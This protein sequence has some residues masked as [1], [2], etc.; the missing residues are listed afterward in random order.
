MKTSTYHY[1]VFDSL[2]DLCARGESGCLEIRKGPF[3]GT[4]YLQGGNVI[5][6]D[7]QGRKEEEALLEMLSWADGMVCW[8]PG[9]TPYRHTCHIPAFELEALWF[10]A[11]SQPK[12]ERRPAPTERVSPRTRELGVSLPK[13]GR[14]DIVFQAQDPAHRPSQ[15]VLSQ[16]LKPAYLIGA[17]PECDI[18]IDHYSVCQMHAALMIEDSIIRLWDLGSNNATHVNGD[19]VDE[20][21]LQSGDTLQ[22]G[23]ITF[24]V[25]LRT[26]KPAP[27]RPAATLGQ[28]GLRQPSVTRAPTGP[29]RFEEIR[30]EKRRSESLNG[31]PLFKLFDT[32]RSGKTPRP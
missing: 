26:Q 27:D 30:A 21:L 18:R 28:P 24:K 2:Q 4:V 14:Y 19:L 16:P 10:N 12:D 9:T 25:L 11:A 23:D 13:L 31:N 6:V 20:A 15:H 22:I 3:A 8:F 17:S 7:F 5:D 1:S 29:L 32:M